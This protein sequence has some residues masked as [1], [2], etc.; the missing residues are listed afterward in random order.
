MQPKMN[1]RFW[2]PFA[3]SLGLFLAPIVVSKLQRSAAAQTVA[4]TSGSL[5]VLDPAGKKK[6]QCPLKQTTVKAAISGFLSRVNVTQEFENTFNEKIEAVYTFPLPQ[7]AAVDDMVMV[8]G[9]RTVRGKILRREEAKA[10]YDAAKTGGQV[11]SLLDQ[12]RPN[13][14][15]QSVANIMPGEKVRIT[16]SYVE[17]LKYEAG[18]YEFVFPMVV[19]PRYMPGVPAATSQGNGTAPDTD[20]VPDASRISPA[21]IPEGM[22][23][24]HDVSLDITIDA[25]IPIDTIGSKSHALNVE[26]NEPRYAQVRL[27]ND[28]VIPNKDFVLRYEVAGQ[29]I[30]DAFLVHRSAKGG[31]FTLI[32][33]PPERVAAEDVTPKELVFVLDTSGSMSGFPIEKA[34]ETISLALNNLYPADTFNLITFAGDT[35][36]LFPE[37]VPAT[38]ENLSRA[39]AFL[40]G[41]SGAGGTEMMKAIKAAL[42]PTDSQKHVRIV[43]FMTDGYVGNDMEIIFEVQKHPNA[44]V[45]AFGIGNGV[46]RFLLDKMAEHGRGEVEYVALNDDGS[47]AAR[48]FHERVRSPLLTD[49]SIDWN[50]MPVTDVYPRSLPDLFG[51]KPLII[52]GRYTGAKK[53]AIRLKGKVAGEEFLREVSVELPETENQHDVLSSLWARRRIDHLMSEDYSG[54]QTGAM[55][56]DLSE[57]I[58]N[59]GLEF[60]LM[61]Q[62]TSFVAVE[63]MIVTDRGRPRRI[64]IPV[65]VPDGVNR[66]AVAGNPELRILA[67]LSS[68][69]AALNTHNFSVTNTVTVTSSSEAIDTT[70]PGG[71]VK[72]GQGVIDPGSL[73]RNERAKAKRQKVDGSGIGGGRGG[74]T[75]GGDRKASGGGGGG[76]ASGPGHGRGSNTDI[77]GADSRDDQRHHPVIAALL[78]R[79]KQP[80]YLPNAEEAK[81]VHDG[82]VEIKVWLSDKSDSVVAKLKELGFELVL[83]PKTSKLLVGRI[84][85]AA[86]QKLIELKEVRFV[87]PQY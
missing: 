25:G 20:Q 11:A 73:T 61:T 45:F 8:V 60:R 5:T 48:R 76:V 86:L 47:A 31:F 3:I 37:P 44:R 41:T 40:S 67:Q 28:S 19:G 10:V 4:E 50:G 17:T 85:L 42:E 79:L 35:R 66:A 81:F 62:F 65:E 14:F 24:G 70:Q 2:L 74:K 56:K 6:T 63:E 36:I 1:T 7:N 16:I 55:K 64:D 29:K 87:A 54:A 34:K 82:K 72:L 52:S 22:R 53:G 33:Q 27:K 59:L 49:I 77:D 21:L 15:T 68:P 43:C 75:G 58:T 13:I 83:D 80:K 9:E 32:L 84:P 78:E 26:Q 69:S 18:S 12:E 23:A 51:A 71:T 39:Q 30:Q 38:S 57:A 46:N